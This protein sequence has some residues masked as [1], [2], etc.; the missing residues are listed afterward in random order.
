MNQEYGKT[1][2]ELLLMELLNKLIHN[3]YNDM[4]ISY[5]LI[6]KEPNKLDMIKCMAID[7][8]DPDKSIEITMNGEEI[9]VSPL[10]DWSFSI[11]DNIFYEL[12]NGYEIRNMPLETHHGI[13]TI[14]NETRDEI[15]YKEGMQKYLSHCFMNGITP[16]IIS[17]LANEY[18]NVMDLYQEKNEGYVILADM[19]IGYN[20]IVLG[21]NEDAP[22]PYATWTTTRYREHGYGIGH[23][24]KNEKD[25][26]HDFESRT[27]ALY[28]ATLERKRNHILRNKGYRHER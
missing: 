18:I 2:K 28:K 11:D 1:N 24:F 15:E 3:E 8:Q 9:D 25:A 14:L 21:H 6:K 5:V 13:W 26:F 22:S 10:Y 23:Y 4:E 16:K 12:E 7:K 19:S 27:N 17:Q 20:T